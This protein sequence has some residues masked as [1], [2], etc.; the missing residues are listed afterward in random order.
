[1]E[2]GDTFVHKKDKHTIIKFE[3]S[4]KYGPLV[5]L[6]R[7][8]DVIW[9]QLLNIVKEYIDI[10][11]KP[12]QPKNRKRYCELHKGDHNFCSFVKYL[13]QY[14]R[15]GGFQC[16]KSKEQYLKIDYFNATGEE[17]EADQYNSDLSPNTW[18]NAMRVYFPQPKKWT[19]EEVN[20]LLPGDVEAK[21]WS[22]STDELI[23]SRMP[24]I[25]DLLSIGFRY[26]TD[27]RTEKIEKAMGEQYE[28]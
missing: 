7:N 14:G 5:V 16:L 1:M 9:R 19:I 3:D 13:A 12:K 4:E 21:K 18:G 6:K 17:L 2:I 20:E 25:L 24:F 22:E 26:G 11:N 10:S 27:H 8:D 28:F 15:I 23:I